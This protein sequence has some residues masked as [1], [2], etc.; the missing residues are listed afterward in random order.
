MTEIGLF[1]AKTKLSEICARVAA[2]KAPVIVTKRGKPLV[3]I[4]PLDS[5]RAGG[6]SVWDRRAEYERK[7]GKF[8]DDLELPEREKQTW[9]NPLMD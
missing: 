8:T 6:K 7:H 9:R 5:R 3:R 1:E 4:E 2:Q